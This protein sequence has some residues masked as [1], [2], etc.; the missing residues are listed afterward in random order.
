MSGQSIIS[1]PYDLDNPD[2]RYELPG[3]LTEI[4]G[5]AY[6]KNDRILC[7]Q[8]EKANIY[9]YNINKKEI[10][11]IYDFGKD[12]DYEGIALAGQTAYVIRSDGKI[13]E[14][15][16]FDSENKKVK[17]HKTPLSANNDTEGL[18]Y[19]SFSNSLYIACKGSPSVEKDNHYEGTKAIYQ[20]SLEKMKLDKEPA[21]QIDLNRLD[22]YMNDDLLKEFSL[23]IAKKLQLIE[24]GTNFQP[25]GLAIHPI[26]DRIYLLSNIGKMLIILNR[27]GKVTDLQKLNM[28]I[29]RQPE[30][31][32]FSPTGDLFI[33]SEGDGGK[34]YILK[35]KLHADE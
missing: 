21:F 23:R 14:V 33:A 31:I 26:H 35:F 32:C 22:S 4:S 5:L 19:D 34:G 20:F 6:Y 11:S 30:G 16:N 29:F 17:E 7:V 9:V 12:G 15:E 28:K 13:F 8:D 18:T 2:E 25:S 10:E 27:Q 24:S 3:S 1:F